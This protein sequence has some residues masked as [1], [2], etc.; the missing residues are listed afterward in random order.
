[1][2]KS[3]NTT[4]YKDWIKSLRLDVDNELT[5]KEY[6]TKRDLD[7]KFAKEFMYHNE[8]NQIVNSSVLLNIHKAIE[9]VDVLLA[10]SMNQLKIK[11]L[12]AYKEI[13]SKRDNKNE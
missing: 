8:I 9:S 6:L 10:I 3:K 2:N 11:D 12:K 7:K 5:E 1:M 4:T 13:K